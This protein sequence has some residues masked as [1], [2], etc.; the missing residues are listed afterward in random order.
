MVYGPGTYPLEA[1]MGSHVYIV[2]RLDATLSEAEAARVQDGMS[3]SAGSAEPFRAEPVQQASF[4]AVERDLKAEMPMLLQRDGHEALY[5]MFTLPTDASDALFT[6]E[7]YAVGAAIGWGGAQLIDNVYEVSGNYPADICHQVTFE[8]PENEAFWSITVYD[9]AGFM[10]ND[11]ANLS[12]NTADMNTDGAYTVSFGCGADAV[13]NI[14]TMNDSGV[15]NLGIR[16]YQPSQQVVDGYRL[17][18]LVTAVGN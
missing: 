3:V 11:L 14:E 9:E 17:L 7:K 18:P 1:H 15:F 8:D 16:H 4:E 12:S 6:P 2:V 5:G 13:N 10:F